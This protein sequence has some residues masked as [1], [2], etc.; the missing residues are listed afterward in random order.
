MAETILSYDSSRGEVGDQY[1]IR[2]QN[3]PERDA[4]VGYSWSMPPGAST[5]T[6]KMALLPQ[7]QITVGT[8]NAEEQ[9]YQNAEV[10]QFE[11][12]KG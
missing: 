5:N 3:I 12:R 8:P 10:A 2:E 6:C 7:D 1:G 4:S 9:R 11:P